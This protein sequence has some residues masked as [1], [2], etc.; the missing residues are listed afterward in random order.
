M[1]SEYGD[2]M[3]GEAMPILRVPENERSLD[4]EKIL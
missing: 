2:E 3:D 4:G 1:R